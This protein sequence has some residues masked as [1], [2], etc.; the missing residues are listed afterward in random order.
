MII[1]EILAPNPRKLSVMW[2]TGNGTQEIIWIF[3]GEDNTTTYNDLWM[4]IL[5]SNSWV[6]VAPATAETV[7]KNFPRIF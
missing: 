5:N 6:L 7:C 4:F 2:I 3:G 1:L